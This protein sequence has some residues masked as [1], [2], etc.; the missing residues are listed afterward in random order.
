FYLKRKLA[1]KLDV[2]PEN[3]LFGSGSNELIVFLCHVFLGQGTNLVMGAEAFAVYFLATAMY[4]G[5]VV[6]VPM[7]EHM[8]DLDA[9]LAAITPETRLMAICNPNNPTGTMVSPEAIDGFIE[10]LPDHVVAI[11][12]EAYFEVMPEEMK[13]DVLK[14][15]RAGKENIIVLRTFS[16]GYGLAGLRIG[17]AIGSPDLIAL[18][19]KVRQPFNVNAMAQ[20]AAMA[21]LDDVTHLV[22]TREM[23]FQGLE[24]FG[25]ELPKLGIE[26]VPSGAN[27][28]LV[29]T[30]NG[31]EV[32]LE[33][34]KRKVI[35]R[36]M[37][38]YGLPDHIRITIGTPEQNRTTLD[39]LKEIMA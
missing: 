24:F 30:G 27:F 6:R 13:P 35:V 5:E 31:R 20:A 12:D 26:T 3:L 8:H 37:D 15:I 18:L 33:L 16:K 28:I 14:H 19:N 34:Q 10:K 25:R 17:Y 39:A 9:M 1:G 11:F 38:P 32:F 21:A 29:K 2:S 22:E 23:V 4:Q 7:P 36:P